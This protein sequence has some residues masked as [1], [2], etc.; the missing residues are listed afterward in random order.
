MSDISLQALL[1]KICSLHGKI[2]IFEN[3]IVLQS[4]DFKALR[5]S[6]EDLGQIIKG[7]RHPKPTAPDKGK[8][9][10]PLETPWPPRLG[11]ISFAA[12]TSRGEA[13]T[14]DEDECH[15]SP[16]HYNLGNATKP[17]GPG[18][19]DTPRAPHRA[20]PLQS[21]SLAPS[22][23]ESK[24]AKIEVPKPYNGMTQGQVAKQ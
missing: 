24:V 22:S 10:D 11:A 16:S 14:K 4:G 23:R 7:Q 18:P 12:G 8:G 1:D 17:L 21:F 9:P 2:K 13:P 19:L 6:V 15:A 5:E 3:K 20:T